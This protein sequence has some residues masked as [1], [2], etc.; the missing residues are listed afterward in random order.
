M[1]ALRFDR[2]GEPGDVLRLDD[3][4]APVPAAGH[5]LVRLRLRPINPA[6]RL[7]VQGR[8]GPRPVLP[9]TPGVEGVGDVVGHGPGVIAP[10]I[11][12]RVAFWRVRGTWQDL[13][14]VPDADV[15]PVP[16][17]LDD[18]QAAQAIAGP[19]AATILAETAM[20]HADGGWLAQ[21]GAGSAFAG[22]LRTLAA[23]AGWRTLDLVRGAP[24]AAA[25]AAEGVPHVLAADDPEVIG[26]AMALT[27]GR[28]VDAALDAVGG[29]TGTLLGRLLGP[30]GVMVVHGVLDG[31]PIEL[32]PGWLIAK[33]ATVT[34]FW[35]DAWVRTAS[36]AERERVAGA[37]FA[38]MASGT[39]ACPVDAIFDLADFRAAL[40]RAAEPGRRGKV[41]L[42]G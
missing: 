9:A 38:A 5:V 7:F 18:T 36:S 1:R 37:A 33:G 42:S 20:R 21:S 26:K 39:L 12:A 31:R 16:H 41:L 13:V 40:A 8:Y 22:L 4:A 14:A 2:L 23:R 11:G 24:R 28:G 35:L 19:I 6:D 15:L 25:L 27:G 10:P 29:P 30:R 32:H 34:G 17:G 3:I